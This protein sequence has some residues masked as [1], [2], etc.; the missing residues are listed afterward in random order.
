[1]KAFLVEEIKAIVFQER[2]DGLVG[3]MTR[4]GLGIDNYYKSV[5]ICHVV[6]EVVVDF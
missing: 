3:T 2:G 1:M 4:L 5:V 6:C